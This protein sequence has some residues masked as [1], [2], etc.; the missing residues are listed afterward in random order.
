MPLSK[1]SDLI[2][3]KC[4]GQEKQCLLQRAGWRSS[5]EKVLELAACVLV[6]LANCND[7]APT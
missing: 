1:H 3:V 5:A 4:H 7:Y 6:V 2:L